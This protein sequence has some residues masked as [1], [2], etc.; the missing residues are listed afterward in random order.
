MF[1]FVNKYSYKTTN[2]CTLL[3]ACCRTSATTSDNLLVCRSSQNPLWQ[4]YASVIYLSDHVSIV[5]RSWH[6]ND[7]CLSAV[8]NWIYRQYDV[9]GK[10]WRHCDGV[11]INCVVRIVTE[12]T[13][14]ECLRND[15]DIR[16]RLTTTWR[17]VSIY[18]QSCDRQ[19]SAEVVSV[20]LEWNWTSNGGV[21]AWD[22]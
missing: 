22:L 14:K 3:A 7:R 19:L 4:S 8:E 6:K 11:P 17:N 2:P 13:M 5:I 15:D 21:V 9:T 18:P 16:H 12:I 1:I 10:L 20:I